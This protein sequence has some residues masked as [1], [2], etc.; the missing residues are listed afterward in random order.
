MALS[1]W[2]VWFGARTARLI[3]LVDRWHDPA[4]RVDSLQ[5]LLHQEIVMF[6]AVTA[7]NMPAVD[8]LYEFSRRQALLSLAALPLSLF[9]GGPAVPGDVNIQPVCA[10]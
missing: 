7:D 3:T 1:G 5:E 9:L 10:G 6:D 2:P 8:R 4:S